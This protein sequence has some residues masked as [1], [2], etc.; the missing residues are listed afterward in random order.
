MELQKAQDEA[1]AEEDG[2]D[3]EEVQTRQ[4]WKPIR[5]ETETES[6]RSPMAILIWFI[7]SLVVADLNFWHEGSY[8]H[9]D[10]LKIPHLGLLLSLLAESM[11]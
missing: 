10:F 11:S 8:L 1:W 5:R 4:G 7:D 2:H 3:V 9:K 6:S